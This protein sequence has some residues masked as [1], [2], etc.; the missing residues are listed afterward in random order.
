M[1]FV[2]R[3][4]ERFF[5]GRVTH[6]IQYVHIS[7]IYHKIQKRYTIHTIH[8][9]IYINIIKGTSENIMVSK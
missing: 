2:K 9:Y 1:L 7:N 5:D 3:H 6:I 8:I 4:F